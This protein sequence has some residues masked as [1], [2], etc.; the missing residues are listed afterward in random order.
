[1]IVPFIILIGGLELNEAAGTALLPITLFAALVG[2]EYYE[3]GDVNFTMS[4]I[5]VIP[6]ALSGAY[7]IWLAKRLPKKMMQRIFAV[8]LIAID[9]YMLLR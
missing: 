5:M 9:F 1:M 2:L 4:A 8:F 7:G 6:G 3:A